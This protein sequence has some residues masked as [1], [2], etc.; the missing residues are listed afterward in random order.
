M[1]MKRIALL[2][3]LVAFSCKKEG[4]VSAYAV[5]TARPASAP[6]AKE[7]ARIGNAA[8][9]ESVTPKPPALQQKLPRMIVRNAEVHIVV[10]DT[11]GATRALTATAEGLG[12][13][14]GDTR[15]WREGEQLRGT[16]TL[17]VPAQ[18][19]TEILAAARKLAIRVESE[20]VT[21][22]D[23]SQEYV[24]LTSQLRNQEAAENELRALMTDVR[25]KVKSATDVIEIY[26]QL[27]TIRGQ[28]ETTKGRMQFLEQSA[29]LSTVK[30][31]LIPDAIAKPIVKPGWQPFAIIKDA[32]R[33]LVATAQW[34]ATVAIWLIVYVLPIGLLIVLPIVLIVRVVRR[35]GVTAA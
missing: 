1:V 2:L 30:V 33:A 10:G 34:L 31:E 32:G 4:R 28:V 11:L 29:A 16:L 24:D 21:S 20:T 25:Q 5:D 14:V 6:Q 8:V 26:Q 22:D 23:V 13:Y 18:R 3:L 12:G 7:G 15:S 17:R 19:L 27:V 35:R 9:T